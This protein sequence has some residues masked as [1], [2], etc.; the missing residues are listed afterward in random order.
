MKRSP[1]AP[2]HH[3][4]FT[5]IEI[6]VA[7]TLL[8]MVSLLAYR[9][10]EAVRQQ[11]QSLAQRHNRWQGISHALNRISHDLQAALP[12]RPGHDG[13]LLPPLQG[14]GGS[15]AIPMEP[16]LMAQPGHEALAPHLL[17]YH[18]Q[19]NRIDLLDWHGM[20]AARLPARYPLLD[21]VTRLELAYLDAAG[22]WQGRWPATPAQALT[23]PRAVRLRLHCAEGFSLERLVDLPNAP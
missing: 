22:Q 8:A 20:D 10:L 1:Y 7:M 6:L 13:Q 4:G 9:G 19:E 21:G 11:A 23:L 5:L 2:G 14:D 15:T 3:A 17:A 12:R 18:W 16:L